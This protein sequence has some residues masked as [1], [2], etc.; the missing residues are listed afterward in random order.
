MM[1]RKVP[2]ADV[3]KS[4][5][6]QSSRRKNTSE[7]VCMSAPGRMSESVWCV[8]SLSREDSAWVGEFTK[9]DLPFFF[10]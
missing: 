1:R 2:T 4:Q 5:E 10:I 9:S 6:K 7:Y 8:K 3:K